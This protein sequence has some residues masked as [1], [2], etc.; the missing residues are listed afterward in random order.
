M[1]AVYISAKFYSPTA[2]KQS[3]AE[4]L[5]FVQKFKMAAVFTFAWVSVNL[6]SQAM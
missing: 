3:A 2:I 1:T 5:L 6:E 4:L